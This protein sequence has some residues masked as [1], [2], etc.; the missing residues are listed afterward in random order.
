MDEGIRKDKKE[1]P[2][3]VLPFCLEMHKVLEMFP[4]ET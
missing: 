2:C 4:S 3:R 1:A